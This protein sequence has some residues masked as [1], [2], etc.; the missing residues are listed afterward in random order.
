MMCK[1]LYPTASGSEERTQAFVWANTKIKNSFIKSDA[2][3]NVE[4]H[5]PGKKIT[6][7]ERAILVA[8]WKL[9]ALRKSG[10]PQI[11][12]RAA[13]HTCPTSGR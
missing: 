1:S 8:R 2:H 4:K 11:C 9:S 5:L 10:A 3:S 7:M 6:L 12:Q 13:A